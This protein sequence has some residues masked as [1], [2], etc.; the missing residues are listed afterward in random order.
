MQRR[1]LLGLGINV[2]AAATLG[3]LLVAEARAADAGRYSAAFAA[4]DA[5]VAQ[6]LRDMNAPGLTLVLADETGVQRTVAYGFGELERRAPLDVAK[7]FHIGSISKSF[8]ALA[9]LQLHDE[10]RLDLH[11]PIKSYLPWLRIDAATREITTHDLLTHSAALANGVLLP[12]DPTVRHRA[13]AAPGTF[14][15]YCNMG[16]EAL[17]L[18]LAKLDGRGL[19]EALRARILVPLGMTATE[20]VITVDIAPRTTGSYQATYRD[21]PY[22]RAGALS[23]ALPS[24]FVNGAGCVASTA[25]DMGLYAAMLLNGG[26]GPRGRI[27]SEAAFTLF[28]QRH[29]AAAEFGKDASYGYG[30]AIDELEGH[31]R[32]RHTGGMESFASA[33]EADLDARVGVFASINAMQGF[34]PRPVAE[35]ALRLMRACRERTA[36]PALPP[37]VP[38]LRVAAAA[39]YAGRF[40]APGGGHLEFVADGERLYLLQD[41]QRVP[42]EPGPVGDGFLVHH[43]DFAHF[44]LLFGRDHDAVVEVAWGTDWYVNGK[45]AGPREF[46]HPP[47]WQAYVGDYWNDGT[48]RVVLR[49]GRLWSDG[50]VPLEPGPDGLFWLRDEPDNPDWVRFLDVADGRA[51]RV[52]VSGA[53]AW[54]I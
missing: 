50:I 48:L 34:R 4:L 53:D 36:L 23:V 30:I 38:A 33:L 10:G 29:I 16:Y 42:L 11:R 15:H 41:G 35:Y 6:F 37:S 24:P 22:P 21:R 47:E 7:L 27:V 13:T 52:Q 12:A 49:C 26:R 9:L 43:P 51:M 8:V 18:L 19:G 17:G 32:L 28:S 46:S 31:R 20:P 39:D 3:P 2:A 1:E 25:H 54:R 14:F 44:V 40:D 5:F 45:Y